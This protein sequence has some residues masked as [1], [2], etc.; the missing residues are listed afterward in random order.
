MLKQPKTNE[1]PVQNMLF[2]N[3][4]DVTEIKYYIALML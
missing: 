3:V 2:K 4:L 1:Y